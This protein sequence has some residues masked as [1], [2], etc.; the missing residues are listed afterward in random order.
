[1]AFKLSTP[2]YKNEPAPVYEADLGP[3]VLGQS[4]KTAL[5]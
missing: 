3:G 2:P 4:N 1:M 5:S